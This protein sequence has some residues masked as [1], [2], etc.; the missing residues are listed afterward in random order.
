MLTQWD[1]I[2]AAERMQAYIESH[3][4]DKITMGSLARAACYSRWHAARLFKEVTGKTP[5][6]YIRL[7]RLSSAAEKLQATPRKVIDVALDFVFDSHEGFTRA[8]ARQFGMPP[9]RFRKTG[10]TIE[11]FLPPQ[12]RDWYT[13]RQRGELTVAETKKPETVFVQ[14]LDWPA[15]KMIV[16]RAKKATHYFEY[17]EELGCDIY[18]QLAAI[19]NTLQEPMG[20]WLPEG[21]QLPG[22][23]QYVQGV[24]VAADYDGEVPDGFEVATLPPCKMMVFQ[25][26]P[27][28]DKDFE[29]AI[30]SLWDL[31]N[32]YRPETYGFTWADDDGPR[33]Q[34]RPEGYR[35]YIEG[36]PVRPV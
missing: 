23:S 3:L 2:K 19:Q 24:E 8:F 12:L 35:G 22:T 4:G 10:A 21:L 28:D 26:P 25:G 31:M 7:R 29:S 32:S 6:E 27:Y 34:L 16:K 14:V 36:R 20:M 1:K 33:F 17:C 15:R 18:D 11:L 30:A 13:R 5:F 9:A